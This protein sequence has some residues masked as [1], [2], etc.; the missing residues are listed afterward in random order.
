VGLPRAADQYGPHLALRAQLEAEDETGWRVVAATG[1]HWRAGPSHVTGADL[2]A[3]QREDRRLLDLAVHEVSFDDGAWRTAMSREVD[4]A[5]VRSIAP[6]VR[7]VAEI[8]AVV[9]RPMR[10]AAPWPLRGGDAFVAD[11]GQNFSGWVRLALPAGADAGGPRADAVARRMAQPGR[12]PDDQAPG[13]R[14]AR[15]A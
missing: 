11:F 6:P 10:G 15:A 9:V 14:P 8:P 12:G 5:V 7:R 4:V 1:E 3:G 13:R 2:I